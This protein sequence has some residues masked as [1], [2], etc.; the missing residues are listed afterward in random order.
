MFTL[1]YRPAGSASRAQDICAS[2][3]VLAS[4][5][6]EGQV[7]LSLFFEI[8]PCEAHGARYPLVTMPRVARIVCPG[9][10]HH[11]TQRGNRGQDIFLNDEDRATFMRLLRKYAIQQMVTVQAYCLMSNHLHLIVTPESLT[12]LSSVMHPV[13]LRYAQHVNDKHSWSGHVFA[14]RYYSCPLD[15]VHLWAA[16]R[17]VEQ[18]PVRA[19][20]VKHAQ[21]WQWSSAPGHC[22]MADDP[23]LDSELMVDW[24]P[25]A[26][27]KWLNGRDERE[28]HA[29]RI[30]TLRGR[31]RGTASFLR[32]LERLLDRSM[33]FRARGRPRKTPIDRA[34]QED[35]GK[36]GQ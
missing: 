14:S 25:K 13:H 19:G 26:W 2:I 36:Q 17:Y 10:A 4:S 23:V 9:A 34:S 28:E 15:K 22:G 30:A 6:K 8:S 31:P 20:I 33:E 12:A 5:K 18:N 3:L 16:M 24:P 27:K 32:K 35:Q 11:V 7:L 29:L 1:V 21:D